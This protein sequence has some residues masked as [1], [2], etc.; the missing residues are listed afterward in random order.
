MTLKRALWHKKVHLSFLFG[1]TIDNNN[2]L[3]F[4]S[5]VANGFI[6]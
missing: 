5:D 4:Q 3:T 1:E 6:R 2:T